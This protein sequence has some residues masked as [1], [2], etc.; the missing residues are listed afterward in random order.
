MWNCGKLLPFSSSFPLQAS[1]NHLF[2]NGNMTLLNID[3]LILGMGAFLVHI[4]FP[5]LFTQMWH[6]QIVFVFL[7]CFSS[8]SDLR[9]KISSFS[10]HNWTHNALHMVNI[11]KI[12]FELF[13]PWKLCSLDVFALVKDIIVFLRFLQ[14]WFI[15][16][17]CKNQDFKQVKCSKGN[18]SQ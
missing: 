10:L 12:T 4:K 3:Y 5:F 2:N 18:E 17:L 6:P 11:L 14:Q 15:F 13:C 1:L 9:P 7:T 16:F 8:V